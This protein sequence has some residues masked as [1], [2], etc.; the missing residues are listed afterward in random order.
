MLSFLVAA[1]IITDTLAY[2][3]HCKRELGFTNTAAKLGYMS[4][5]D[6]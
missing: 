6:S 2:A 3:E 1:S 5:F 4:C